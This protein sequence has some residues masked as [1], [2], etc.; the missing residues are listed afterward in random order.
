MIDNS[1]SDPKKTFEL[2]WSCI[3]KD[4]AH[5]EMSDRAIKSHTSD[6]TYSQ[7]LRGRI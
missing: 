5:C 6:V 2:I 7:V 4:V 1:I 3:L